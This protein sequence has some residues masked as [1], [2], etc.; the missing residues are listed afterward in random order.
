MAHSILFFG[1]ERLATGVTTEAPVL[2]ALLAAGY[3]VTGLV[4]AQ[5]Q[6]SASRKKR[7]L[8]IIQVAEEH[9]IPV[10]A[11]SNLREAASDIERFKAEIGVLVAY[12]KI[13]PQE[14]IDL[15][16][17]GIV[18]IHPS[19]LPQ[20][21]GSTPIESVILNGESVTGVSLMSLTVNMDAGP[22]YD[23]C[24]ISL[25]GTETKQDLADKLADLGKDMLIEHLPAICDGT[26]KPKT[27]KDSDATYDVRIEKG[28]RE[29]DFNKTAEE[30]EKEVRA[31]AGWPRTH[32]TIGMS[33]V[34][35]TKA[36]VQAIDG[37]PGTLWLEA[38]QIGMHAKTGVLVFDRLTPVGRKEMDG[39]SFIAGYKPTD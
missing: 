29:L 12:G 13:V 8:E 17:R 23:Q 32:C 15:F 1:N 3:H 36:H 16:P 34:V 26:L 6:S 20:H 19:L 18:N 11:P 28:S 10:I 37:V 39:S 27:Q 14:I 2:K 21:R 22:V 4:V 7:D 33:E 24:K 38:K 31:Y 30:L 35:I 5:K 9:A 25:E